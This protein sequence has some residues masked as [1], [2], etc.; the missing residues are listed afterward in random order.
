MTPRTQAWAALLLAGTLAAGCSCGDDDD[1][2]GA[3]L[4]LLAEIGAQGGTFEMEGLTGV[5]PAGSVDDGATMVV[6]GEISADVAAPSGAISPVYQIEID[7]QLREPATLE[8]VYGVDALAG[9][10]P[11]ALRVASSRDGLVWDC[12]PMTAPREQTT[13]VLATVNHMSFWV[14]RF[15][16]CG[17]QGDCTAPEV[18]FDPGPD[19]V[20]AMPCAGDADC[21]TDSFC[22]CGICSR[23]SCDAAE[24][25][26]LGSTTCSVDEGRGVCLPGCTPF[27]RCGDPEEQQLCS[28]GGRCAFQESALCPDLF[29]CE[30]GDTCLHQWCVPATAGCA[31]GVDPGCDCETPPEE[32]AEVAHEDCENEQDDD[33]DDLID[34]A[35]PDCANAPP[36]TAGLPED[37][38]NAS[39]DD[40]DD[41][42]DCEDPDC[43]EEVACGGDVVRFF[44]GTFDDGDWEIAEITTVGGAPAPTAAQALA[45]GNPGAYRAMTHEFSASDFMESVRVFHRYRRAEHDPGA[46]GAIATIDFGLDHLGDRDVGEGFAVYQDN[47]VYEAAYEIVEGGAGWGSRTR[48]GLR[49]ADFLSADATSPDFSASGSPLRFGYLRANSTTPP[50]PDLSIA[51]GADN[52]AVA[53]HLGGGQ[54]GDED[55]VNAQDDD[56]DALVD[57]LDPDCNAN[58]TCADGPWPIEITA[59]GRRASRGPIPEDVDWLAFQD[60]DGAWTELTG[61]AGVYS[62]LV[63]DPDGRYG[64]AWGC[65]DVSTRVSVQYAV[66]TQAGELRVAG[67]FAAAGATARISGTTLGGEC[68]EINVYNQTL[69]PCYPAG[70]FVD[71][72]IGTPADVFA[73]DVTDGEQV[74]TR[75]LIQR[76]VPVVGDTNVTID[77]DGPE[78]FDLERHS[79]TDFAWIAFRTAN[80][81]GL[82]FGFGSNVLEYGGVPLAAQHEGDGH[83]AIVPSAGGVEYYFFKAPVDVVPGVPP[84]DL[85]GVIGS[86]V[87]AEPYPL[88]A[89]DVDAMPAGSHAIELT[90]AGGG[91]AF[92]NVRA[93]TAWLA[94]GLHMETPDLFG[95]PS[96]GAVYEPGAAPTGQFSLYGGVDA[97]AVDCFTASVQRGYARDGLRCPF[98]GAAVTF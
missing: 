32:C 63:E 50:T 17:A 2:P 40:G 44:D 12:E 87:G 83:M 48:E 10:S 55:C 88:F 9:R 26:C 66:A 91:G 4:A 67:C 84:P 72:P 46:Q 18:C 62:A 75:G 93:T 61:D 74:P 35:D 73:V 57:C 96:W 21:P 76:D 15:N 65:N 97:D 8:F 60:G 92:W 41:L 90:L 27:D 64:I 68:V 54:A 77:F 85:P 23:D 81:S 20:C 37:C 13:S 49:A 25:D 34:C 31:C 29:A 86:V 22:S 89:V 16:P 98:R 71:I 59:F 51:H 36:C 30:G 94:G 33:D 5:I 39:D 19:G 47:V 7:Q 79:R 43:A 1:G 24:D 28:P 3:E 14:L 53:L 78:A 38:G 11:L 95:L 82:T 69:A 6:R 80:D 45:G 56:G 42:V 58:A 70:W 52:F